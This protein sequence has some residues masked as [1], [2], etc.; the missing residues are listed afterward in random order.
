M[1]G[2]SLKWHYGLEFFLVEFGNDIIIQTNYLCQE[3]E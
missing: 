3:V 1:Y 2:G